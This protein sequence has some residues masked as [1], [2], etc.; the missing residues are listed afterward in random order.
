MSEAMLDSSEAFHISLD[1]ENGVSAVDA[2]DR[3]IAYARAARAS[4][5]HIDPG[6][7]DSAVRMRIDGMLHAVACMRTDT[8]GEVIARIK[9]LAGLRT[10]EHHRPQDGRFRITDGEGRMDVRVSIVPTYYGENAVLRLLMERL[11]D[12]TFEALGFDNAHASA[13][14]SA[15]ASP[16]GMILA[17]GPTGSGKTTTLYAMLRIL[18]KESVSVVTIEDPI[19]YAIDGVR[20]IAVNERTG[21]TFAHGLRAMVRQDPDILMVGEIRDPETAALA[22]NSA[23]TGHL[24]LSTVHT[25]DAVTALVRFLEMGIEPYLIGATVNAVIAQR[26][27]RRICMKCVS[28]HAPSQRE[29]AFL[30]RLGGEPFE[31]DR[32]MCGKGC[33]FCRGTGYA[34]RIG[35]SE[36]LSVDEGIRAALLDRVP[37]VALRSAARAQGMRTLAS[38]GIDKV[39]RGITTLDEVAR[40]SRETV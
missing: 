27:V 28:A 14:R 13:I 8:A 18:A 25:T 29:R 24:L 6:E 2:L 37:D 1:D 15:L 35:V 7:S 20:Q 9:V 5:I 38:D 12:A 31:S 23:L 3:L 4:D 32:L 39:R 33:S 21:V 22:V 16:Y 34:G 36:V 40:I 17:T 11:E 19:E 10:D 30:E 26:L